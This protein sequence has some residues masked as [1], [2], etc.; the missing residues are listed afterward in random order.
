MVSS[1]VVVENCR[2]M[3]VEETYNQP[4]EKVSSMVVVVE[5]CR[6]MVVEE[7]CSLL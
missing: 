7:I 6:H 4:L 5:N 1:M 3:V 2:H